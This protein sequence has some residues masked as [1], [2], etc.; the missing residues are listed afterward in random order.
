MYIVNLHCLGNVCH[1]HV[2]QTPMIHL[3]FKMR[4]YEALLDGWKSQDMN[5][6]AL[7]P[8]LIY[9]VVCT[10]TYSEIW[11]PCMVCH[12]QKPH[13]SVTSVAPIKCAL[14]NG[15]LQFIFGGNAN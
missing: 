11:Q 12:V 15:T 2:Q 5:P 3:Q 9:P 6:Q 14:S 1:G 7:A 4:L 10:S 8:L 13:F